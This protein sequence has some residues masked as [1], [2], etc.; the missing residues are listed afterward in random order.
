[1]AERINKTATAEIVELHGKKYV[2]TL[3][4]KGEPI[5]IAFG[6]DYNTY[7]TCPPIQGNECPIGYDEECRFGEIWCIVSEPG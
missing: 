6:G 7:I 1:M 2:A 5:I 4:E 3:D